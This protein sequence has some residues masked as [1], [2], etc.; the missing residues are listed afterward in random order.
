MLRLNT[1]K[2][3]PGATKNTKR[4]GRGTGSGQGGTAGKGH[5]GQK[6]R[7][8][9]TVRVGFEGGQTPLYRKVPKHG[10]TNIARRSIAV[11]NLN[12]LDRA[13]QKEVSLASLREAKVVRGRYDRLTVLATGEISKA[14]SVKAHKVSPKAEEKIKKAGGSVEILPIPGRQGKRTER[15]RAKKTSVAAKKK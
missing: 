6:A 13:A 7:S 4:L 2:A 15:K 8:G 10:F 12:D 11:V 9:G 3:Q 14:V 5:K 1:I